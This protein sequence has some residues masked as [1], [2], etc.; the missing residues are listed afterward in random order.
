[1]AHYQSREHHIFIMVLW[2]VSWCVWLCKLGTPL[3][4]T[5]SSFQFF[6]AWVRQEWNDHSN[7]ESD[8]GQPLCRKN[9]LPWRNRVISPLIMLIGYT[10][11]NGM[12]HPSTQSDYSKQTNQSL[13]QKCSPNTDKFSNVYIIRE[14][15]QVF[16]KEWA[17]PVPHVAPVT[18]YR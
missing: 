2:Y 14:W 8:K 18:I 3:Y 4:F 1:M 7:G 11:T 13:M 16:L 6:C 12:V 15:N 9:Y 10:D 5:N 17:F